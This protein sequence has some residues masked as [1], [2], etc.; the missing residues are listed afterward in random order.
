MAVQD[1]SIKYFFS[2]HY[3][4]GFTD[5]LKNSFNLGVK[6][7]VDGILY[8]VVTPEVTTLDSRHPFQRLRA[9]DRSRHEPCR[10]GDL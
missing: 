1:P 9:I 8:N 6:R 4:W 5:A 7:L 10:R 2:T 3:C